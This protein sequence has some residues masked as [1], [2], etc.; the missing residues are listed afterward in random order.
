MWTPDADIRREAALRGR[1]AS[2]LRWAPG[3]VGSGVLVHCLTAIGA[4]CGLFALTCAADRNFV[5]CF[6]W[7]GLA[8][9]IDG[10]DGALARRFRVAETAP[11]IDGATLDLVVDY[12]TYVVVPLFAVWRSIDG[13][14]AF[15]VSICAGVAAVGS[16]LYFADSRMKTDDNWFRGFPA[17]W[18][19]LAVYWFAFS[20]PVWTAELVL[21]VFTALLFAPIAIVHPLRVARLRL[22][23]VIISMVW[24]A[25]A[26]AA[27][28]GVA[29]LSWLAK[30]GLILSG[31]YF[32]GL[33]AVR[34]RVE[35]TDCR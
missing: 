30:T 9:L 1:A 4:G 29:G 16:A 3:F 27:M 7:L 20:P 19:M 17:C 14:H 31:L 13:A 11:R 34:G 6:S 5:G 32:I 22:T 23:T 8:L 24:V 33:S 21:L 35:R 25:S 2:D 10:V 28:S 15:G 26:A 12:L 18:N